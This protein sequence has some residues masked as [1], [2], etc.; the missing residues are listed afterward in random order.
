MID[1]LGLD[2]LLDRRI[3]RLSGGERRRVGLGRALLSSPDL[4]LLDEPTNGLDENMCHRVLDLILEALARSAA[5]C[6]VVSHHIEHL[7]RLTGELA[8]MRRGRFVAH[9]DAGSALLNAAAAG[10]PAGCINRLCLQVQRHDPQAGM[11][12]LMP[13]NA[14]QATDHRIIRVAYSPRLRTGCE[15]VVLLDSNDVVLA[16]APVE[17]VSMQ[18]RLRGRISRVVER[19]GGVWCEV[20]AGV[21]LTA[22]ITRQAAAEF[23]IETG[24]PIWAMF[25]AAA[26]RAYPSG[27][28]VDHAAPP[29]PPESTG[30]DAIDV[31]PAF[32]ARRPR[33]N[34]AIPGGMSRTQGVI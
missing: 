21:R 26:V 30:R 2:R 24:Q 14:D 4:L 22:R 16:M 6:V 17:T 20:D 9:G 28:G 31:V 11:S 33:A 25:K 29:E 1:R 23:G 34:R 12:E 13:V 32:P 27:L 18:N 10:S 5:P 15:A 7:L 8:V 19:G 3:G